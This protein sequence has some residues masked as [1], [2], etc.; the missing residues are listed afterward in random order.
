VQT[1]NFSIERIICCTDVGHSSY[2]VSVSCLGASRD[3][4]FVD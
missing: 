4:C 3:T 1:V 2:Y